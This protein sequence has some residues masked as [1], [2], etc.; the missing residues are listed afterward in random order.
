M[1]KSITIANSEPSWK[2][3]ANYFTRPRTP[4]SC[5]HFMPVWVRGCCPDCAACSH[6]P[7]GTTHLR[8]LFLARDPLWNQ[9]S[10]LYADKRGCAICL[11]GKGSDCERPGTQ[12]KLSRQVW[13]GS[14]FGAV[15]P[16]PWTIFRGVMSLPAGSWMRI[17]ILKS[18]FAR[19]SGTISRES[20]NQAQIRCTQ[21][22]VQDRVRSAVTDS[23]AAHLVADVPVSVFLSGGIDSG[24]M[25]GLASQLGAKVEGVTI[26]FKEFERVALDEIPVAASIA[27]HYRFNHHIRHVGRAEFE[28]DLPRFI[29]AMD[30]PTID[31]LNTW[32][33]SK[34]VAEQGYKVVLSGVGGDELFYGYSLTRD[35]PRL[36]RLTRRIAA[37]PRRARTDRGL[38]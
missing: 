20:W 12:Q 36:L 14:T 35:I 33:A 24:T 9:A 27:S 16:E 3:S 2:T 29:D 11:T 15:F 18:I 28:E 10:L 7:F 22:E 17:Q 1:G 13:R 19:R 26:G 5:W 8:E 34:A 21:E 30:Q 32:F 4:K 37:I 38:G 31:G 25:V 6:L 23:V